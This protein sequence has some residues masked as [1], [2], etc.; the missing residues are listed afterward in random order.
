MPWHYLT[1]IEAAF[2]L[3][4]MRVILR[5]VPFKHIAP[6]LGTAREETPQTTITTHQTSIERVRWAIHRIAPLLPGETVC[7]PRALAGAQMLRMRGIPSTLY[8]GVSLK[9]EEMKAHAWVRSGSIIVTGK[10]E[11]PYYTPVATFALLYRPATAV[12]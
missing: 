11:M 12:E 5:F 8:L 6:R 1:F 7:F 10:R 4:I 2:W 3:V 9:N